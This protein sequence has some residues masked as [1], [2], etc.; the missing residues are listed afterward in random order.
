MHITDLALSHFRNFEQEKISFSPRKNFILGENGQGKT[1]LLESIYYLGYLESF[2]TSLDGDLIQLNQT[3]P[4]SIKAEVSDN[5]DE[6]RLELIFSGRKKNIKRNGVS[7]ASRSDYLGSF[8][9]VL[10]SGTDLYMV[11]GEPEIR[12]RYLDHLITGKDPRYDKKLQTYQKVLSQRNAML[13]H[14]SELRG[15]KPSQLEELSLW[16]EQLIKSAYGIWKERMLTLTQLLPLADQFHRAISGSKEGM[17]IQYHFSLEGLE[18]QT[19][20][21]FSALEALFKEGLKKAR[22]VELSRGYTILG[23]HRDDLLFRINEK[24]ARKYGSQGQQRTL[25]MALKLAELDLV[26]QE[27]QVVPV[28]L[29]DDV[30]AELDLERQKFLLQAIR[31]EVQTIITTTHLEDFEK[32]WVE[33]AATFRVQDG[34]IT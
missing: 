20:S 30:M 8:R 4:A 21:D 26:R 16:D 5:Q 28:L 29:L 9:A 12:R 3:L 11:K 19:L 1:N 31:P 32:S 23:P 7:I 24:D 27:S 18:N 13:K 22:P 33:G 2:R 6:Y 17:A 10:F 34:K 14:L 15:I 25:A